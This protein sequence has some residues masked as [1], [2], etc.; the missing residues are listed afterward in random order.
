MLRESKYTRIGENLS[1]EKK[2]NNNQL[3]TLRFLS[4]SLS[5]TGLGKTL[6]AALRTIPGER[7]EG[8]WTGEARFRALSVRLSIMTCFSIIIDAGGPAPGN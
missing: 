3:K 8:Q 6:Q 5:T 7:C 2:N 4:V 1:T